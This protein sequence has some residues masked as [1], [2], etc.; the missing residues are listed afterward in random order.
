[1]FRI[2][3]QILKISSRFETVSLTEQLKIKLTLKIEANRVKNKKHFFEKWSNTSTF[4]L[5]NFVTFSVSRLND[6]VPVA[7]AMVLD[8]VSQENFLSCEV[9]RV[10]SKMRHLQA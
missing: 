9:V 4:S 5:I 2:K 1:M 10:I 6:D 7:E 8:D 3:K